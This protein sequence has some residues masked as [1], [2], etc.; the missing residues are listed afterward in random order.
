MSPRMTG[1]CA[2][3]SPAK[4]SVLF[5]I[6]SITGNQLTRA[7]PFASLLSARGW[8]VAIIGPGRKDEP[9]Y[10][11][12]PTVKVERIPDRPLRDKFRWIL[13]RVARHDAI[14][15]CK[16]C[17]EGTMAAAIAKRSGKKLIFDL[18]DDDLRNWIFDLRTD[19]HR[20]GARGVVA[21]LP[22]FL[23]IFINFSAR[24]L[25]DRLTV[26]ST[27]LRRRYG[28]TV[29]YVPVDSRVFRGM[30]SDIPGNRIVMYAGAIRAHKGVETLVEAFS[31]V[32]SAVADAKLFLVGPRF[33][34]SLSWNA[35]SR[36]IKNVPDVFC[37]GFQP[38]QSIPQ[39]LAK[40]DCLVIPS[41]DNPIHRAQSPVKLMYYMGANRPIVATPV[42]E[43]PIILT[44]EES[45]LLVPPSDPDRMSEAIIRVLTQADLASRLA[46][47]ARKAFLEKY[48]ADAVADRILNIYCSAGTKR[49]DLERPRTQ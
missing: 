8:E 34:D 15:I 22:G 36:T 17:W 12:D 43:I 21:S 24:V 3:G 20:I 45:A 49:L 47:N 5:V 11:E 7:Y 40:A 10:I 28:G 23:V 2:E 13:A 37:P 38:I 30:T 16:P 39:W 46:A 32:K 33:E 41:P 31:K 19:A 48:C 18:D 4:Q 14:C 42:G 29:V 1:K 25:A 6:S 35:M 9:P 26:A 44:H 27:T